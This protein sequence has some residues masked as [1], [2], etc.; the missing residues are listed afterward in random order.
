MSSQRQPLLADSKG[1]TFNY[2]SVNSQDGVSRTPGIGTGAL[3]YRPDPLR[4]YILMVLC[5]MNI[6][7]AMAWISFAPVAYPAAEYY[8]TSANVI[9]GLSIVFMVATIPFGLLAIW[10]LDTHGLR[11]AFVLGSWLN[12]IGLIV[13][14][15]STLKFLINYHDQLPVYVVFAGQTLTAIA[16]AFFLFA[17]TKLA[18]VWFPDNHRAL[19][20]TIG[21]TSNPLGIL[22]AFVASPML[23]D[24][25]KDIPVM[26]GWF[27]VPGA[28]GCFMASLCIYKGKPEIPPSASA[29]MD[30]EPFF[31]GIKK[32]FTN[33]AY[34]ML[35]ISFGAGFALFS[36]LSSL[37]SQIVCVKG[38]NDVF[39]GICGAA[40]I[41]AGFF[42]AM[43]AGL[44]VDSS[45]KF[46]LTAKVTFSMSVVFICAF[47]IASQQE[48]Q[49]V[50]LAISTAGFG[51][52]GFATLPISYELGV[53]AT[54]PVAE[55]TSGGFLAMSG[56]I[57]GIVL[58]L[59]GQYLAVDISPED[60]EIQVCSKDNGVKDLKYTALMFAVYSVVAAILYVFGVRTKYHR[61]LAEERDRVPWMKIVKV[62][63]LTK[64]VLPDQPQR[65][66]VQ[67]GKK[68]CCL[69]RYD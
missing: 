12:L 49:S 51:F 3:Q 14:Y 38:Y 20:N 15:V 48:D 31:T 69:E 35:F 53:E 27:I 2:N 8:H 41:I 34:V 4:W 29:A 32:L 46:G 40:I 24:T 68:H 21:S 22:V 9:N 36:A 62:A 44:Y 7:N 28:I 50:L 16:Q 45:K 60:E 33:K 65:E 63:I 23:V 11:A 56:Q 67:Q 26:L 59:V 5:V 61:L 30:S 52:F 43:I 37:L 64:H 55:G 10:V 47:Y 54:Y 42:G 13:R 58:V 1:D 6:S 39:A 25:A 17:P 19:A 57:Q 18:A 66:F